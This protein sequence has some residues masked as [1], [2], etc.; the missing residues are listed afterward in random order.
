MTRK[1]GTPSSYSNGCRCVECREAHRIRIAEQ[2]AA[3]TGKA[4]THGS[5]S[6]YQ[7]WHCRHP[8]CRA[9]QAAYRKALRKET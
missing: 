4:H 2:R 7:N 6:A 8:K 1:H 9:A 3:R 5:V